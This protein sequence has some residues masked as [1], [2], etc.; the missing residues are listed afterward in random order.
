MHG[1]LGFRLPK[2]AEIPVTATGMI[3][4]CGPEPALAFVQADDCKWLAA[5]AGNA[6]NCHVLNHDSPGSRGVLLLGNPPAAES[7]RAFTARVPL[8][9]LSAG[10]RPF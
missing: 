1:G 6:P 9:A 8:V 5:L 7:L 10:M 3:A 4:S 2:V